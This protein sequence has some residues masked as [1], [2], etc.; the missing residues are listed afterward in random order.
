[1]SAVDVPCGRKFHP[2]TRDKLLAAPAAAAQQQ[3]TEGG[4][5]LGPQVQS[6]ESEGG[7][8]SHSVPFGMVDAHRGEEPLVEEL[9]KPA[10]DDPFHHAGQDE[11]GGVVVGV[12]R[13]F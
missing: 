4:D 2:L 8:A 6:V 13:S 1:M 7:T 5:S 10:A 11:G 12:P 3:L 9:R